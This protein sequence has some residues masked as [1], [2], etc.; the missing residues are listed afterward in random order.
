MDEKDYNIVL[1]KDDL[2]FI[3]QYVELRNF[4][5]D[6]L[7]TEKVNVEQTVEWINQNDVDVVGIADQNIILGIVMIYY[8]KDGEVTVF[9]REKNKGIGSILLDIGEK[10]ARKRINTIWSWVLED[11]KIAKHVFLKNGYFVSE[12]SKERI[13]NGKNYFGTVFKKYI[14]GQ[15]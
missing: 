3:K 15:G 11:N 13:F 5:S 12:E 9:A 2:N 14:N 4:Y 7:L 6:L 8:N 10:T 1:I